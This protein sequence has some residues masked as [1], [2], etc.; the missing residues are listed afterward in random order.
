MLSE[1]FNA[2]RLSRLALWLIQCCERT[3]HPQR[4]FDVEGVIGRQTMI[5]A[6]GLDQA[7]DLIER[8]VIERW[9]QRSQIR[10]K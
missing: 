10:E 1:T 4:Q 3:H 8:S 9:A 2:E 5:A 7:M 6:Y